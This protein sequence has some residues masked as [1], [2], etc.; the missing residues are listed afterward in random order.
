[1]SPKNWGPP[2]WTFFHTLAEK[3]NEDK[4]ETVGPELFRY[5][6]SICNNLPCPECTSHAKYFLSKVDPRRVNS[7]KALKDLL[8]VFH[9]IVSKRKNKPLFRYV[10]F[11]EAYKDKN[12]IVTFNNFLKAYSTDG[13]MKLMT[14]NFHR[15]RFLIN[16]KKWFAANITNFDLT[17]YQPI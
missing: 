7:K 15:K 10:E 16:F 9:N 2:I 1:M 6:A 4:F 11:L 14:E 3:I 17:K 13:N 12:L 8:F 5:I